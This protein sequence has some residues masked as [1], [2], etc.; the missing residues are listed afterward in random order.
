VF[1]Q[2]T[3]FDKG[4]FILKYPKVFFLKLFM[5]RIKIENK[6]SKELA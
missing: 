3:P 1:L 4:A 6:E 5:I 2:N